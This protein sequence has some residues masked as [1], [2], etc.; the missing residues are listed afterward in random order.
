MSANLQLIAR[1]HLT[2]SKLSVYR[3]PVW[4]WH[5]SEAERKAALAI[6]LREHFDVD[7][8]DRVLEERTLKANQK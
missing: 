4:A 7:L 3:R 5:L 1:P 6:T 2:R 8:L